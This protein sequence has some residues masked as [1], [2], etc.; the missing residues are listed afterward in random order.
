MTYN[1]GIIG[2]GHI[3]E[4]MSRTLQQLPQACSYAVASRSHAKATAFAAKWGFAHAYGSYEELIADPNV[5]LIYVATPHSLHYAHVR[6]C[7]MAGKAVLCEKAFMANAAEAE[8][9][10]ALARERGVYV[11][12][13]MWIRYM[14][15]MAKIVELVRSGA[16]GRPHTLTANLCYPISHKERIM[17]PEL[18]GGALLDIGVYTLHFAAMIFGSEP[19]RISSAC[20]KTSTGMDA[21]DSITLW[22]DDNRMAQLHCS[23]YA[24]SDRMGVISGDEGHIIV[25]NINNPQRV[26]VVDADYREVATY[27]APPQITGFEYEVCAALNAIEHGDIENAFMP[28][29]ETLRIMHLMDALRNEWGVHFPNDEHAPEI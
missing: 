10:I 24:K 17:R 8:S 4:K 5:D 2:A 12:E 15:L 16:I 25:E 29:D 11:A 6:Q 3:A 26:H 1:I 27:D 13:A 28:H 22:Y 7:I 20:T 9:I 21:Q 18:G 19:Q 23:I 14:P